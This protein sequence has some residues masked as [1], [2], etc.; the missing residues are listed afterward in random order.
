MLDRKGLLSYLAITFGLITALGLFIGELSQQHQSSILAGWTHG[1]FNSQAY[2]VWRI[3]FPT[4]NPLLGGIT[5][6]VGIDAWFATG[7][8]QARS[9]G[10]SGDSTI[11]LIYLE[12]G[13]CHL[14]CIFQWSQC[15]A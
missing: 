2:S 4:V 5:G 13:V 6:L 8:W 1:L 14:D 7:M 10:A 11:G 15:Y 3:L 9:A 12:K